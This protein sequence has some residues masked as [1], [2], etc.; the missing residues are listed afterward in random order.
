MWFL[1]F[2]RGTSCPPVPAWLPWLPCMLFMGQ[3]QRR[4]RGRP[5]A[6]SPVQ[7]PSGAP[8]HTFS[9]RSLRSMQPLNPQPTSFPFALTQT[10]QE[11]TSCCH[12]ANHTDTPSFSP[13][14]LLGVRLADRSDGSPAFPGSLPI[15]FHTGST[16]CAH[17]ISSWHLLLEGLGIHTQGE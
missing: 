11:L 13:S 15:S 3:R 10:G 17:F 16:V 2:R 8:A 6:V 5:S 12:P 14:P 7:A 1:C 9:L 4:G